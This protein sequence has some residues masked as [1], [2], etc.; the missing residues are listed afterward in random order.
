[1]ASGAVVLSVEETEKSPVSGGIVALFQP[2][3]RIESFVIFCRQMYSL[4]K[5]GIP[6]LRAMKGLAES[7]TDKP[8]Q[9]ALEGVCD[10]LAQGQSLSNA[11]TGSVFSDLFISLIKV[12]EN[13]GRLDESMLQLAEYFEKEIDTLRRIKA[14]FRYPSFVFMVLF[15][16]VIFLNFTVIPQFVGIFS[17]FGADLP[18]PT[19]ILMSTSAFMIEFWWVLALGCAGIFLGFNSWKT[20]NPAGSLGINTK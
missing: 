7:T 5:A 19:M 16:A 13:T 15:G 12:G 6:L 3:V 9:V 14:A 2:K 10:D 18:L 1:M 4:M 8:L 11:M 17:K 20:P